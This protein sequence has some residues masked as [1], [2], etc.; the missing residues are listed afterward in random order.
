M[1]GK[2]SSLNIPFEFV[3]AV[4]GREITSEYLETN[5]IHINEKFR[6]PYTN[7]TITMGEI[8]C[9]LSHHKAW[10]MAHRDGIK[11]P[12]ILEDD[13]NFLKDFENILKSI[14]KDSPKFDI[15]YLTRNLIGE[16]TGIHSALPSGHKLITPGFSYWTAAYMLTSESVKKLLESNF[17]KELIVV[18][19][20]IPMLYTKIES[21]YF[22]IS[23]YTIDDF[24]GLAIEPHIVTPKPDTFLTSETEGQP[25][26][27]IKYEN[28]FYENRIQVVTV[29]TDPVDGYKRFVDSANMY[30]FPFECLGFGEPWGGNDMAQGP[31]GGHKVVLLKQY[32]ERF[33][34]DDERLILFSDC[35]D[36]VVSGSPDQVLSQFKYIQENT[37]CDVMFSSEALLWPDESIADQFPVRGTPYRYLNSGGFIGSIKSLKKLTKQSI[38]SS[39]DDQYYYQMEYLKSCR[40]E[41]ELNIILDDFAFIFQTLSSH[42]DQIKIDHEQSK[43]VNELTNSRPLI[44]H[45][46]GGK[47]SKQF[48]NHLCN[49][50]NSKYRDVYGYKDNHSDLSR[51]EKLNYHE[52]PT[53]CVIIWIDDVNYIHNIK[54]LYDQ[55][56]PR[57]QLE[58]II[59]T[60]SEMIDVICDPKITKYDY[61]FI[62]RTKH[63]ITDRHL[64][65]KLLCSNLDIVSPMLSDEIKEKGYW[66]VPKIS[67]SILIHSEKIKKI[68]KSFLEKEKE[69]LKSFD[70][71]LSDIISSKYDF[72]YMVNFN[73]YGY[74]Q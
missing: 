67:G 29:G 48:L 18:D 59:A 13:V 36:A 42:F 17:L 23:N 50:I 19:E 63:V 41:S 45:G 49:Y 35:Y 31:G 47:D 33:D 32:L 55:K 56:Y 38:K 14:L 53:I 20:F 71:E 1:L 44:I 68:Q 65:E 11:Y 27:V 30:S 24:V 74:I 46:N 73:K 39:D 34:D 66:N 58:F 43:V 51:L 5:E 26:Y 61:V 8:G 7:T 6:N 54:N 69:N 60:N 3:D 52:Y 72:M 4:Y 9:S 40:G 16:D 28:N 12:I 15:L 64:F 22:S 62:G 25:F 2:L 37:G 21:E 57:S 10:I 70:E